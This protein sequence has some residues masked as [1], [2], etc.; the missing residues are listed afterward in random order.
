TGKEVAAVGVLLDFEATPRALGLTDETGEANDGEGG[1]GPGG[2]LE[3]PAAGGDDL[4]GTA[5][6]IQSAAVTNPG[7]ANEE[8]QSPL[9]AEADLLGGGACRA[10]I[11]RGRLIGVSSHQSVIIVN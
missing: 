11:S 2:E 7:V 3:D 4:T 8:R 5:A 1:K 6:G 9:D 10:D